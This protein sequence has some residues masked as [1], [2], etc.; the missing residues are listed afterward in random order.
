[1]GTH[2]QSNFVSA[3]PAAAFF[4]AA[5]TGIALSIPGRIAWGDTPSL[6]DAIR[7]TEALGGW[8]VQTS[9][10]PGVGTEPEDIVNR[11]DF[12]LD[13]IRGGGD[14]VGPLSHP[15]EWRLSSTDAWLETAA[16]GAIL[17]ARCDI[18]RGAKGDG[19]PAPSWGELAARLAILEQALDDG[20]SAGDIVPDDSTPCEFAK[21]EARLQDFQEWSNGQDP[22][23]P[24]PTVDELYD[25]TKPLLRF[26]G[27]ANLWVL[28]EAQEVLA[29]NYIR[30][31]WDEVPGWHPNSVEVNAVMDDF[32]SRI[33]PFCEG[34]VVPTEATP[35]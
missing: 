24:R 15:S 4:T 16:L 18:W 28:I 6:E 26:G 34:H 2:A 14:R 19:N 21:Y 32:Y 11:L 3:R 25:E 35:E 8:Y 30:Q 17:K 33:A 29:D 9:K 12:F 13:I 22:G 27:N 20:L 5:L 7:T 10:L 31:P 23:A 1:M